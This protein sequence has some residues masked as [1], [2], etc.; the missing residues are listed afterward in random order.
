MIKKYSKKSYKG[1]RKTSSNKSKTK[2]SPKQ[3][4]MEQLVGIWFNEYFQ[5][6]R[7]APYQEE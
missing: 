1:T 3:A 5:G 7:P 6:G 4:K 2:Q